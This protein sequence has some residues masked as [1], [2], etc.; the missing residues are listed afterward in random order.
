MGSDLIGVFN[1]WTGVLEGAL[2]EVLK[3]R[4]NFPLFLFYDS[5]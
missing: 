3:V 2:K 1:I 5:G 4:I